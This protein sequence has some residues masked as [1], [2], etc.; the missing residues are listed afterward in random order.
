MKNVW[1]VG[2]SEVSPKFMLQN[3]LAYVWGSSMSK[4]FTNRIRD[5]KEGDIVFL[6]K[7]KK[8]G[9][10]KIGVVKSRPFYCFNAE[11]DNSIYEEQKIKKSNDILI[12]K[13]LEKLNCS[14]IC[15]HSQKQI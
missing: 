5:V 12:I 1:K 8:D 4:Y 9:I 13:K 15:R 6:A 11:F 2:I 7:S 10:K 14:D 3:N